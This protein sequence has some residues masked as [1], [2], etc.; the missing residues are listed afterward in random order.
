MIQNESKLIVTDNS[1]GKLASCI[2]VLGSSKK[3]YAYIGDFLKVS[4]KKC[5]SKHKVKKGFVY[6]AILIRTKTKF[7]RNNGNFF[8][9]GDNS[10][11]LLNSKFEPFCSRI[12]GPVLRE[13]KSN[14]IFK[15]IL[16]NTV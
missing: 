8:E 1:G 12:F 5:S 9:F 13:F 16:F 14:K 10:I 3:R 2:K 11:V 4:L 7:I 15:N 6:N